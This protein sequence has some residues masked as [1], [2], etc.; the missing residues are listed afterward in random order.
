MKLRKDEFLRR[1][2][3]HIF[4]GAVLVAALAL[5]AAYTTVSLPDLILQLAKSIAVMIFLAAV[6]AMLLKGFMTLRVLESNESKLEKIAEA[7]EKN[8]FELEQINRNT[9]LS[10][11]V[12]SIVFREA[13]KDSL[14]EHVFDKLHQQ[15][16]EATYELIDE[17]AHRSEYLELA[18]Q[19]RDQA[20]RYRNATDQERENQ[21][22]MH[23]EEHLGNYQ[24]TTASLQIER[25]IR[26]N[27]QSQKALSMRQK[28]YDKKQERKTILLTAW[29]DAVKRQDPDRSIEILNELDSYLTP[30]EGLALQEAARDVF[31]T[32][33]HNLGVQFSLAVS[34]KHWSKALDIGR[35]IVT[36][37]PNSRMAKEIRE[38]IDILVERGQQ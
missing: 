9:H 18:N 10:E 24:W 37:F 2:K 25:L 23:I 34:E 33:L 30:N 17:I 1:F 13:D 22:I 36:G 21:V 11:A 12:K 16:F 35:Q 7:V 8:R 38:K 31:R 19:L 29:D 14:R 20:D 32:K 15:N 6:I 26:A 28:L 27:P 4:F 3:W 5:L